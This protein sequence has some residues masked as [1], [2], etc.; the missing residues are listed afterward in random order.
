[1]LGQKKEPS[2][3]SVVNLLALQSLTP[4]I[5]GGAATQTTT[6]VDMGVAKQRDEIFVVDVGTLTNV[7]KGFAR[8]LESVDNGVFKEVCVLP[9]AAGFKTAVFQRTS[10]YLKVK[11]DYEFVQ[12]DEED[13]QPS[14]LP[15]S[16][17]VIQ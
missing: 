3:N 17:K 1:M 10:R 9:I 7:D 15:I 16:L 2:I 8:L 14:L 4:T 12:V 11:L 6:A 5:E 13:P